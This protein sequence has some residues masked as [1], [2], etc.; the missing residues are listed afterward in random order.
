MDTLSIEERPLAV[1]YFVLDTMRSLF[2]S[3]INPADE[4]RIHVG[5]VTEEDIASLRKHDVDVFE[6]PKPIE[7]LSA[8]YKLLVQVSRGD[9]E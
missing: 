7:D 4:M 6:A 2:L 8:L 1:G 3:G 9:G 5:L